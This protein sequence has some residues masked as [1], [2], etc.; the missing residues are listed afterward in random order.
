MR[1]IGLLMLLTGALVA[2][3]S[4]PT[5]GSDPGATAASRGAEQNQEATP[6]AVEDG[7][8]ASQHARGAEQGDEPTCP[9]LAAQARGA[10][11]G[12]TAGCSGKGKHAGEPCPCAAAGKPCSA[13]GE[14]RDC[15]GGCE[16]GCDGSCEKDCA[17]DCGCKDGCT[18]GCKNKEGCTGG[19]KGAHDEASP[20]AMAPATGCPYLDAHDHHDVGARPHAAAGVRL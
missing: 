4:E 8:A 3:E 12:E 14:G 11:Q 17:G 19:C 13:K 18:G 2:C 1:W 16:K 5:T 6:A 15:A 20:H 7:E 10:E 9:H